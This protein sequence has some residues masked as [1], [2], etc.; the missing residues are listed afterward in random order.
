MS[1]P[2]VFKRY[3]PFFYTNYTKQ[4]QNPILKELKHT[5]NDYVAT[6]SYKHET[7]YSVAEQIG[8]F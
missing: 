4:P 2:V 3:L 8:H 5:L 7:D 1:A 6:A